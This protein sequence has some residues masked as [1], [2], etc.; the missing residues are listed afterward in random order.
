ML[1]SLSNGQGQSDR[2]VV[3][4]SAETATNHQVLIV[5]DNPDIRAYLKERLEQEYQVL[6]AIDGQDGWDKAHMQSP[7]LIIADIAMP[8]MDGIEL[9]AK[10]KSNI[11]TSHIPVVLLTARTSL[12]YQLDGLET[13]ADDYITKP[14]NMQLLLARIKNLIH[15]RKELQQRFA[16]NFDLSPNGVVLNSLDEQLLS[17]VKLLIERNLDNADF[18]VEQMA[19]ALHMSRMQLYRKTKALTDFSPQQLI[20]HFRLQRAA[21]LLESGQYNVSEV[22]YRVGYNDLKSFRTQFKKAFGVSPSGYETKA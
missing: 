16:K 7:D 14:F 5:E 20:R 12:I 8:R 4:S 1:R 21:Q 22:T 9:C 2:E 15:T 19:D 13:G 10:V 6:E 11:H 17:Q 3:A 18:T